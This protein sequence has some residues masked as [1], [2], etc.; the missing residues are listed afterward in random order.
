MKMKSMALIGIGML[1]TL[2]IQKYGA[3][4]MKKAKK[5]VDKKMTELDKQIEQMM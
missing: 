1:G 2:A 3:P 4:I 5:T